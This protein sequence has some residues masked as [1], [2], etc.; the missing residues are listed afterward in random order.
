MNSH[1]RF[2]FTDRMR[3]KVLG[4]SVP[5]HARRFWFCFGGL[6]FTVFVFQLLTGIFLTFFYQPTPERAYSSVFYISN[7]VDY[8]WFIRTTHAWGSTLM[9]VFLVV[10]M[11]RVFITASYKHPREFNWVV[12]VFLLVVTMAFGLTG[13]LLPWDQKAFW[14]ATVIVD[15]VRQVPLVGDPLAGVLLGG[16]TIGAPALTRFFS[17]HVVVLPLAV[18]ILLAAHFWMVRKQG[19]SGPL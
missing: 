13:R 3:S 11:L 5:D 16:S 10:H 2:D 1:R 8:G 17:L 6:T 14:G 18:G 9:V 12:G 4:E 19:I 7:Y 15:L